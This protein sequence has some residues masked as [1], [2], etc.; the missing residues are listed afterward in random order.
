MGMWCPFRSSSFSW[1]V[2]GSAWGLELAGR[3]E[4]RPTQWTPVNQENSL[5]I[6]GERAFCNLGTWDCGLTGDMIH[7]GTLW[8][9]YSNQK[10]YLAWRGGYTCWIR[11]VPGL[12]APL[13]SGVFRNHNSDHVIPNLSTVPNYCTQGWNFH[14]LARN[15]SPHTMCPLATFCAASLLFII[16]SFYKVPLYL[17]PC[18]FPAGKAV[19][20]S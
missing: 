1:V 14:A 16:S 3:W 4:I 19:P 11:S 18:S 13:L 20:P 5:D 2:E 17:Y 15:A 10:C 7:A 8:C 9:D 6:L 12:I